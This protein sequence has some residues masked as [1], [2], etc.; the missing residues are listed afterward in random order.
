MF[1]WKFWLG[2]GG[3]KFGGKRMGGEWRLDLKKD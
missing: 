3:G 2:V 1:W